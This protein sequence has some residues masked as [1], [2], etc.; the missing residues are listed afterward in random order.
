MNKAQGD[1]RQ[2]IALARELANG[3]LALASVLENSLEFLGASE[4]FERALALAP[5]NARVLRDY[6]SFAVYMG[7]TEAGLKAAQRSVVLDPLNFDNH[8]SLGE[9][10]YI[11]RRY[12]ESIRAFTAA[13]L[14]APDDAFINGWLGFAYYSSGDYQSARTA[15]EGPGHEIIKQFCRA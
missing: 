14:L 3:H 15:C 13:K 12:N 6:G 2:A 4:E 5:G 1:A 8:F 9:S 7:R 10:L 11:A